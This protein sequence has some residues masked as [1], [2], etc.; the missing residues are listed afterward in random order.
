MKLYLIYENRCD[1]GTHE[2]YN[3]TNILMV[4]TNYDKAKQT[5]N[6]LYDGFIKE[7]ESN[8]YIVA[9]E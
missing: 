8:V 9:E 3:Y 6:N 1:R 5:L 7:I 4:C 2:T